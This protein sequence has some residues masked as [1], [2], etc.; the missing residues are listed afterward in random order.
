MTAL[1]GRG[2]DRRQEAARGPEHRQG[3]RIL[4]HR[5]HRRERRHRQQQG[6]GRPGGKQPEQPQRPEDGQVE[7]ADATPL[8]RQRVASRLRRRRQPMSSNTAASAT[9]ARRSSI[10]TWTCW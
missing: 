3:Q 2:E 7:Q 4:Q 5:Q 1:A 9:A 6:E 8:Q 10:G